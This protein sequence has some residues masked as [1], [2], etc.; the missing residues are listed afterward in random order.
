MGSVLVIVHVLALMLGAAGGFGAMLTLGALIL[1]G[2]TA[3]WVDQML[4][5]L[6]GA[7]I[8]PGLFVA[9]VALVALFVLRSWPET[10]F[11]PLS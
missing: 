6:T 4:V 8:A 7:D 11:R 5:S 10:A 9:V 1:I 2:G 3:P